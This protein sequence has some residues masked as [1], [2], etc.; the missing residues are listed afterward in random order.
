M[1]D[2]IQMEYDGDI[3]A[4][5]AEK[6]GDNNL[7]SLYGLAQ[8]LSPA[9]LEA[10]KTELVEAHLSMFAVWHH[11]WV[12][13]KIEPDDDP[14]SFV[15]DFLLEVLACAESIDPD[16]IHYSERADC[17]RLLAELPLTPEKKLAWLQQAI[18]TYEIALTKPGFTG[19]NAAL[20]NTLLDRMLLTGQFDTP[21]FEEVLRL[22]RLVLLDYSEDAFSSFL[23]TSFRLL[24]FPFAGNWQWHHRF[25]D[26]L[27]ATAA[28]F[29]RHDSYIYLVWADEL[30]RLLGYEEGSISPE[31]AGQLQ[32]KS[33]E[34]LAFVQDYQ[35]EDTEKLN[36]LGNCFEKLAGQLT[37]VAA[38]LA[39][40]ETALKYYTQGQ[41][42]NPAAWTFPVYATNVLLAMAKIHHAQGHTPKVIELFETGR[43]LFS[44]NLYPGDFQL[45]IYRGD[46]LIEYA[47]LA[48]DFQ[49]PEI[50]REAEAIL[51]IAKEQGKQFHSHP[52][53]SLAKVALKLGDKAKCLAIL[54]ECHTLFSQYHDRH[55]AL[56]DEDFRDVWGEDLF[57]DSSAK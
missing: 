47:R 19:L 26:E 51:L 48:Y 46:F 11:D 18:E 28:R 14:E 24:E 40:Y 41:G 7:G 53:L 9:Q 2:N 25:M 17:Y 35:T 10:H 33:I 45:A 52:Y 55:L 42:I 8:R 1:E 31:Y 38:Q 29:S 21:A 3:S 34:V 30:T 50:L 56:E 20:A 57:K 4:E 5:I 22:H 49:A 12:C 39:L 13:D 27:A 15:R 43:E 54:Q 16:T 36:R 44:N 37:G 6:L 23:F 32:Q